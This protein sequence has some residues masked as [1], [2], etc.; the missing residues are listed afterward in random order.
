ELGLDAADRDAMLAIGAKR[1]MAYRALVHNRARGVVERF[2]PRCL[3]RI[4]RA[5]LEAEVD[6]FLHERG[7]QSPFLR[8]VPRE[9]VDWAEPRWRR[10]AD[11][12]V[13]FAELARY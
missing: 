1:L 8:D 10:A 6:A 5:A 7:I 2:L 9:F 13:T 11:R 12:G 3:S 4:G